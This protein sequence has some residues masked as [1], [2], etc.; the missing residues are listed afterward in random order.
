VNAEQYAKAKELFLEIVDKPPRV[1]EEKLRA[2]E[3]DDPNL[4]REVRLLIVNHNSRTIVGPTVQSGGTTRSTESLVSQPLRRLHYWFVG[5]LFPIAV[6]L[7]SCAIIGL[8]GWFLKNEMLRRAEADYRDVLDSLSS[9][10][11][12]AI[13]LWSEGHMLRVADWGHDPKLQ[14]LVNQLQETCDQYRQSGDLSEK[15]R[16][17]PAQ[18]EVK[19]VF[20]RVASR[21]IRIDSFLGRATQESAGE[22]KLKYA[23]WNSNFQLLADW[24]FD[25]NDKVIF[26]QAASSSGK[27]MLSRVV[28][29]RA[30][31]MVLPNPT[32]E[33]VSKDYPLETKDQYVMFFI[34]IFAPPRPD[35]VVGSASLEVTGIIMVRSNQYINELREILSQSIIPGGQCYLVSATGVITSVVADLEKLQNHPQWQQKDG[36]PEII[37]CLDPGAN[38]LAN[39]RIEGTPSSWPATMAARSLRNKQSGDSLKSYRDYRGVDVVG[40]WRWMDNANMGLVFEVPLARAFRNMN[41]VRNAFLGLLSIP[42][43]FVAV[44]VGASFFRRLR[45]IDLI[46]R[47]V[48]PY[49]IGKKIGEGGLGVVYLGTHRSLDRKA[50]VK[51]VRPGVVSKSTMKRFEREVKL[52]ASFEHPHAVSIYDFG[53]SKDGLLYCAMQYV[54]GITLGQLVSFTGDLPLARTVHLLAKT[55]EALAAAHEFGLIHRDIKPQNVMISRKG[56]SDGIKVVDFGLAKNIAA[57]LNRDATATRVVMGTPGFI[58]PERLESP[59]IADPKIDIFSFG[60][61]A[62]YL[63]V[64]KVPPMGISKEAFMDLARPRLKSSEIDSDIMSRLVSFVIQCVS[65]IPE[66]RPSSMQLVYE[67]LESLRDLC[68]WTLQEAEAWW[69]G[70]DASLHKWV[71]SSMDDPKLR[72]ERAG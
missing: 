66:D 52:A 1:V 33:T 37:Y 10:K 22:L 59:W 14:E 47:F 72:T 31:H 27:I 20:D 32:D 24:Q 8:L 70:N 55:A 61:L 58:A 4:A 42:L 7:C 19:C 50:A 28:E 9:E 34:P 6:A 38:L 54:D 69:R 17:A 35:A 64:G 15:L 45:E 44:L 49:R 13:E 18:R 56:P 43:G 68:P 51:L 12:K 48:G 71:G 62:I 39:S 57:N 11:K 41:F 65:T 30:V 36:P 23:I 3:G 5:G 21:P 46:N 40:S 25:T 26:G 60:V 29:N 2:I 63:V 53:I 67:E 16:N